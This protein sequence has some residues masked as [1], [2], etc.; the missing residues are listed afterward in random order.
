[1][2]QVKRKT[3]EK[4]VLPN[5]V[6]LRLLVNKTDKRDNNA[7]NVT[8]EV[9]Y[10]PH[11]IITMRVNKTTL[12]SLQHEGKDHLKRRLSIKPS[13]RTFTE[14]ISINFDTFTGKKDQNKG[15]DVFSGNNQHH[16]S[17]LLIGLY[18][19][20]DLDVIK[21]KI[22]FI[23]LRNPLKLADE[24]YQQKSFDS[25]TMRALMLGTIESI[26]ESKMYREIIRPAFESTVNRLFDKE[27]DENQK[28]ALRALSA[29]ENIFT[30]KHELVND[31]FPYQNSTK[32]RKRFN[33]FLLNTADLC[34]NGSE[35]REYDALPE[36]AGGKCRIYQKEN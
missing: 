33:D 29:F 9:I 3:L 23:T 31:Y 20:G 15:R 4:E 14:D 18:T 22:D 34:V 30:A 24:N 13:D 26:K 2:A 12:L 27:S 1:M 25:K 7:K 6:T 11:D 16:R 32:D 17:P 35:V 28:N 36:L 8:V 19:K 10:S 5:G 21:R